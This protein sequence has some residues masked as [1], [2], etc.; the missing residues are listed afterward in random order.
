M[1]AVSRAWGHLTL[2]GKV[3]RLHVL[4]TTVTV[5]ALR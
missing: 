4:P 3:N 1:T 2:P 5:G